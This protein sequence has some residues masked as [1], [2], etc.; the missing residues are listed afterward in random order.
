VALR[1][2][3]NRLLEPDAMAVIDPSIL[4]VDVCGSSA[5]ES[6]LRGNNLDL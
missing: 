1:V 3:F 2:V 5:A 4:R 6:L